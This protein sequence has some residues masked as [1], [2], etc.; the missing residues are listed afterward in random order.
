MMD[1]RPIRNE[2]D[3]HWA[4]REIAPYFDNQPELGTPEGDRFEVLATLISAYEDRVHSVPDADP[5]E[6]L[7]FAIESMGRTQAELAALLGSRARASEILNRKRK[8]SLEWINKISEAWHIPLEALA[9]PYELRGK[10][11]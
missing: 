10:A 8:L 6:V 2:T 5:I 11:A 4:L 3:Y 7:H 9:R 1:V